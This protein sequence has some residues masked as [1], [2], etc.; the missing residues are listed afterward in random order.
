ML[1]IFKVETEKRV[2]G[3]STPYTY[4]DYAICIGE[5]KRI[6]LL[7]MSTPDLSG[8]CNIFKLSFRGLKPHWELVS[9]EVF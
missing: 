4:T 8:K 9:N 7:E 5:A 6:Q 3:F 2:C 1:G